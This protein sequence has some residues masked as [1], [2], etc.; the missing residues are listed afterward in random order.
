MQEHEVRPLR[1]R[2]IRRWRRRGDAEA[3]RTVGPIAERRGSELSAAVDQV[4]VGI[5]R[6]VVIVG[7]RGDRLADARA[8]G[9]VPRSPRVSRDE[10]A[11]HLLLQI[12]HG[13]VPFA[14]KVAA[15]GGHLAPG[16]G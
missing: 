3:R 15:K 6:V 11:L 14:A 2:R 1:D 13:G 4:L 12:E 7:E 10:R 16:G 9:S 5:D 8:I